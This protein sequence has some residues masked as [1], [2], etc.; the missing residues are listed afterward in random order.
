[1]VLQEADKK[2]IVI[3]TEGAIRNRHK[4]TWAGIKE[5]AKDM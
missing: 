4:G 3:E 1:M 2:G 5:R